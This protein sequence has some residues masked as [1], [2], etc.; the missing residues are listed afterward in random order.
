MPFNLLRRDLAKEFRGR[1]LLREKFATATYFVEIQIESVDTLVGPNV[2]LASLVAKKCQDYIPIAL[3]WLDERL[4][5]IGG[6]KDQKLEDIVE[7]EINLLLFDFTD[8]LGQRL[9]NIAYEEFKIFAK[10]KQDYKLYKKQTGVKLIVN[11]ASLAASIALTA[12]VGWTGVG[13]VVGA[14]MIVRSASLLAQE[15]FALARSTEVV[16][17]RI[18]KHLADLK[19]HLKKSQSGLKNTAK[20]AASTVLSQVLAI[21]IKGAFATVEALEK[22]FALL[23]NKVKLNKKSAVK[24]AADIPKLLNEQKKIDDE[25]AKTL[26]EEIILSDPQRGTFRNALSVLEARQNTNAAKLHILLDGVH[27]HMAYVNE[28]EGLSIMYHSEVKKLKASYNPNAVKVAKVA[29][30]FVMAAGSFAAGNFSQPEAL[31]HDLDESAK[32]L[33]TA[34]NLA[35]ESLTV[36]KEVGATAYSI[37]RKQHH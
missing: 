7:R 34:L 6:F 33:V 15:L 37:A 9:Q 36:V 28:M 16:F 4:H 25:I 30:Q 5:K 3:H 22:E 8:Q 31:L 12:G 20:Q 29:T 18:I 2:V 11:G 27:N 32:A 17:G 26:P 10:Q 35:N 19:G 1:E 24:L 23:E 21:E 13:T 14:V